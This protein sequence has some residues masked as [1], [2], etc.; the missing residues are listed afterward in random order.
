VLELYADKQSS[1]DPA[2]LKDTSKKM[3]YDVIGIKAV[4]SAA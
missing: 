3:I 4:E 1:F 2:K